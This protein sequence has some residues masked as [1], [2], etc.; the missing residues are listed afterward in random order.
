[1]NFIDYILLI[2][3]LIGFILGYKDGLIRKI[4]GLIGFILAIFLAT[5]YS[6]RFGQNLAP[7]FHNEINI[8]KILAWV[9]IFFT[10]VIVASL[11]KRLIHPADKVNKFINKFLGGLAGALQISFVVSILLLFLNMLDFPKEIDKNKSVLYASVYNI[12][13]TVLEIFVGPDFKPEGFVRDYIKSKDRDTIP[14]K[15]SK[16]PVNLDSLNNNDK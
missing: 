13:P 15:F 12:F 14:T 6:D 10:I 11:V 4:I 2:I 7:Y 1:M 16:P 8:S 5:K 3:I 9:I